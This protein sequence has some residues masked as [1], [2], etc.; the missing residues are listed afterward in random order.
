MCPIFLYVEETHRGQRVS[1]K[2]FNEIEIYLSSQ[3]I[4]KVYLITDHEGLYE[5]YGWS[6]V[7]LVEEDETNEQIRLY[8]KEIN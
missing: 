3:G 7:T 4:S 5:K 8:G 6:F 1:E 2:L